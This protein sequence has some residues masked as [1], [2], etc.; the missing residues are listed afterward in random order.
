MKRT[1]G[2]FL[3]VALTLFVFPASAQKGSEWKKM[4]GKPKEMERDKAQCMQKSQKGAGRAARAMQGQ[5][6]SLC[7]KEKG[8]LQVK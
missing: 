8:Y 2:L 3:F 4:G 7:M 5:R 1:A 6:F